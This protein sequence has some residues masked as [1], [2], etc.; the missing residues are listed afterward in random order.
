MFN[1]NTIQQLKNDVGV[2]VLT[3]LMQVF[4]A[5]STKLVQQLSSNIDRTDE[6]ERLAHSLK[7][8]ARSYGADQLA[9]IAADIEILAKNNPETQ[10]I[11][12]KIAFLNEI[13]T[14]TVKALPT[15]D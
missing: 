7:S 15:F 1:P 13:H 12:T 8:C 10:N 11:E 14:K 3:Q 4:M 2:D 5:E 6:L 9:N